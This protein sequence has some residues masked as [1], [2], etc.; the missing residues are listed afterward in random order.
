MTRDPTP[1]IRILIAED[2]PLIR[3]AI[4]STA[5]TQG[6]TIV[7]EAGTGLEA[8][9][10]TFEL[11]PDVILM[12]IE[13]PGITGLEA[14]RRIQTQRPTPTI[15]I[16]AYAD[17]EL[18]TDAVQSGAGAYLLKPPDATG[19]ACSISVAMARHA[20]LM[21]LQSLLKQRDLLVREV[22]HRVANQLGATSTLL[23]LQARRVT[24]PRARIALMEA[25]NRIRVMA[26]IHGR[27]QSSCSQTHI[28]LGTFLAGLAREL[29][30]G[31]RPDLDFCVD[32]PSSPCI[33]ASETAIT[34]GLL[35]HEMV[36]NAIRHA[37]SNQHRGMIEF[38]IHQETGGQISLSVRDNGS[39]LPCG[40]DPGNT[41]SLGLMIISSLTK[42]LGGCLE[43]TRCHPGTDCNLT[44]TPTHRIPHE[45]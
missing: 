29:V 45:T 40:F 21:H 6:Y 24:S 14:T 17:P 30:N 9:S 25:E 38:S 22:Y 26:Q 42:H 18:L 20:D 2:D 35:V 5:L 8:V 19:L 37:F 27:L 4:R 31:L 23:N 15:I 34:C 32:L 10:L 44:F 13:M 28:C 43:Y 1:P 33:T 39:G 3:C 36:M 16:T 7:G 12:D 41:A 11:Q